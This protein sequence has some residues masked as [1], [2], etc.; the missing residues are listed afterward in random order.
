MARS[1]NIRVNLIDNIFVVLIAFIV[2]FSI[3]WVGILIINALL[4]LPAA[5][6]RNLASNMKEYHVISV[7]ISLFS[8]ILG[9]I[10]SYYNN[11]ATGP[12]IVIIASIFF[13]ISLGVSSKV[14]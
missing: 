1:K 7:L 13:F 4:I 11:T 12:T 9:L 3:K 8:G 6:S 5:S 10:L 14:K 2:M